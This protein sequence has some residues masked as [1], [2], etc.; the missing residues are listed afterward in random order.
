MKP[1]KLKC[2]MKKGKKGKWEGEREGGR[3][4]GERGGEKG[5]EGERKEGQ[6]KKEKIFHI[7][8][9]KIIKFNFHSLLI[10]PSIILSHCLS[11]RSQYI[12]I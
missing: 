1:S 9:T 12:H 3:K 4:K 2:R 7:A 11:E 5:M 10:E 6:K 8:P